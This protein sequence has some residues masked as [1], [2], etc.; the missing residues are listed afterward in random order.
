MEEKVRST[1]QAAATFCA[2]RPVS[3]GGAAHYV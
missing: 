2:A 3:D 1:A